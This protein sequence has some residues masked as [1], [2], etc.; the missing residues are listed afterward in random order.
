M[1]QCCC[2]RSARHGLCVFL[3]AGIVANSHFANFGDVWKHLP[4]AEVLRVR[5][6]R[7]YWE[8]H[9]GSAT[10]GLTDSPT[11]RH[12]ALHLLRTAPTDPDVSGS[13]DHDALRA[14]PGIYPGSATLASHVLGRACRYVLC[15]IDPASADSLRTMGHA[16]NLELRVIEGDGISA[17]RQESATYDRHSADVLVHVDPFD[18]FE[19]TTPDA[20]TPIELAGDLA[21]AGYRLFY[22]YGYESIEDR[23]WAKAAISRRA[24]NVD[25][26]CGDMLVPSPFVYPDRTGA[27]GC[28][29]VL[30]NMTSVE[31]AACRRLGAALERICVTDRLPSNE[32]SRVQFLE[33]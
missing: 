6:A 29:I 7:E 24:P 3:Q 31:V 18:P 8:T 17:I 16:R 9:A 32:P 13:A 26:W 14:A 33:M 21:A 1:G 20:L 22:R 12:G 30:A 2:I 27:W 25:V 23:G 10:Y 15:D 19:R 11:R 5:P 4:L 28:G